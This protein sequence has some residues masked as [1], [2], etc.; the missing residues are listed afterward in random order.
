MKHQL[1]ALALLAISTAPISAQNC[2]LPAPLA[3]ICQNAPLLCGNY[4]E[5]YCSTTAGLTPDQP[6][7]AGGPIPLF[8]N[9][10]WLRISPCFDSIAIDF[11][12]SECQVGNE[13][14]FFLL[15]GECDTMTLR[16]FASAQ[17]GSVAHLMANGLT[18]GEIYFLVVDGLNNAECKFQAHVVYGIGTAAPGPVLTCDCTNNYVDGPVDV[19][20]GEIVQY[21]IVAGSCTM[22]FGPPVGGNGYFCCPPP[23]DA[24]PSSKDSSV[25][26]WIVPSWMIIVGDSINVTSIT[27]QVDSSLLGI[28]TV[29]SGTVSYYWE[30]IHLP[31]DSTIFCSCCVGCKPGDAPLDV[32]MHHDVEISY[33]T[34][35]CVQPCCIVNG[36]SYCAPGTY[37][38]EQTNCLTKKLV[39]TADW[40]MPLAVAGP[41]G[42]LNCYINSLTLGGGSSSGPNYTYHWSGPGISPSGNNQ[43]FLT[44]TA[45]GAY[46]LLVTNTANG[47]TDTDM[48]FVSQDFSIPSVTI[49]PLPKVCQ[50]A[51]VTLTANANP[52]FVQYTWS[53]NMMGQQITI[54][55]PSTSSYSVTVSNPANGCT[56]T[57]SVLV[58]VTPNIIMNLPPKTICEGDCVWVAGDEFCSPGHYLAVTQSFQG[59]DSIISFSINVIPYLVTNHGI[60]GT[61]TCEVPSISFMG[62]TYNQ[63]GNYA[64]PKA[65]GCGEHQFSIDLDVLPPLVALGQQ[66]EICAGQAA[67]LAVS[68]ILQG[69]EY[70]WS[71][72]AIGTQIEV[73]PT[74]TATYTVTAQN[75]ANGCLA[76]DLVT[77]NVVQSV[78]T[79]LG[80]IGTL[81]CAQL[82]INFL[83]NTYTQPGQYTEP[84]PGGCGNNLFIIL[85]NSTPPWCPIIPVPPVC[86]GESTS[87]Q[88]APLS[89]SNLSYLWS[90]GE[91]TQEV[92]V[93][94]FATTT[95]TLTATDPST[96]CT[97]VITT[98]V[99][100][101]QPQLVPLGLVGTLTCAQ[102]CLTF[103]G[104]EYCQ[105]GTYS[106]TENCEIKEFQI[107]QDLALPTVQLGV[108]GTLTCA[109]PCL[110]FNGVEYCQPGTYSVTENCEIKEFQIAQDL[111]LPTVQLGVVGT[112]TCAQPCL[113]YNGVE[114]CQPGAY[115]V[116]GNCENIEFQIGDLPPVWLELGEDQTIAADE[117]AEL[118]GQ[119][120][121]IP[122]IITWHNSTD[123][124]PETHLGITVQPVENTL[125]FL[126]IQDL[127][128]CLLKDSV[129]VL[130]EGG[131]YAPN[132]IR[133]LSA[134]LNGWF[135]LFA[136]PNHVA[137]IQ[138]LEIFDRWGNMVF[139]RKNFP[140]N[141]SESGWNGTHNGQMVNPAVFVWKATLLLKNGSTEQV[142]G[143]V[144]V[145]R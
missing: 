27:V 84:I 55:P 130:V 3:D 38:V 145:V 137:E 21:S 74:A 108:V 124:M 40:A 113:T 61:L 103:N 14:R 26:H 120:N 86:A 11:Q 95:Y 4:L 60:V 46:T 85:G 121:A 67:T 70:T 88:T 18:P 131:W 138:L 22:T 99:E 30:I 129:W 16:S 127:N 143:D 128:G 100:V 54:E 8:E 118:L 48:A 78:D 15:S 66:Q 123:T 122:A 76:F 34:L 82:E 89:P 43:P 28:D 126:E 125:Y 29:L 24:C 71:N 115:S 104:V 91:T 13:L 83:G 17:D 10:G 142:V 33:C 75:L 23:P 117:S 90:T 79:D 42:I 109:Q 6:V 52:S 105:P 19:C 80:V 44:V 68:P 9:N 41:G 65:N 25:L 39:V 5:G 116:Q 47:C 92:T 37:I 35:T 51:E 72:G 135:T 53:N 69:V 96:G 77:V 139:S 112:L 114:Y 45:P 32:V 136:S 110:I 144:T 94:P 7:S 119:T 97:S 107:A 101:N 81:D 20:P 106:V 73:S 140:P 12:V 57:A 98:T 59:C 58:E 133:P 31:S 1:L 63:P 2:N 56:N 50:F 87:L 64:V 36:Q 134:E 49:P 132:V 93:T 102:P 111:A 141:Q 62:N